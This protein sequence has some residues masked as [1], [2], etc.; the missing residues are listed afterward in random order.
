MYPFWRKLKRRQCEKMETAPTLPMWAL[1]QFNRLCYVRETG[2]NHFFGFNI[3]ADLWSN[4]KTI[5]N[6]ASLMIK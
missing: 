3:D 2:F 4:I 5:S 6:A 1:S